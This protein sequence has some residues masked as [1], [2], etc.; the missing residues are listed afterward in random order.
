[1]AAPSPFADSSPLEVADAI[2]Q[3]GSALS[4]FHSQLLALVA[5]ADERGDWREDGATSMAG[6]LCA[7]LGLRS[8]NA[9]EWVRVAHSLESLPE[10]ASAFAEGRLSWDQ[11]RPLTEFATPERDAEQ[12]SDACG[13]SASFLEVQARRARQV[14]R[15]EAETQEQRKF[16]RMWQN[17]REGFRLA[18]RLPMAD[19]AAVAE[20]LNRIADQGDPS[21]P[22]TDRLADALKDLAS[23]RLAE[24]PDPDRACVVVHVDAAALTGEAEGSAQ[25][26]GEYPV[27]MEVTQRLAC[28]S[29]L[30]VVAEGPDGVPVGIG[31]ASRTIPAWLWRQIKYR[32]GGQCRFP[33][34]RHRRW[35]HG[36]HIEW[37]S[38]GGRTDLDNICSLCPHCHKLVHELGWTVS[39][40][41]NGVLT[42]TSPTG[43]V[44][45]TGPPG[46]RPEVR[47]D[48]ERALG[49]AS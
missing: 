31:R 1:M 15:A 44:L 21:E 29:R 4:A 8:A 26:D 45:T 49:R 10:C 43:R 32:D 5:L 12:A 47:E 38:R 28:D 37:W 23:T 46:L 18:A 25:V 13:S 19:G 41:A 3:L 40:N 34:C 2:G 11:V 14:S 7:R 17:D 30:E 6:W 42:F 9:A 36:H 35:L 16:V 48:M 20:A 39:G 27:A 22:L 24:D 33:G